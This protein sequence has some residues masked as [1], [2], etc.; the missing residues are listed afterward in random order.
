MGFRMTLNRSSVLSAAIV[1]GSFSLSACNV[2]DVV[3]GVD[4][5][6]NPADDAAVVATGEV[7]SLDSIVGFYEWHEDHGTDGRD[8][9]YIEID[10]YSNV[11]WY[12]FQGDS[13]DNNG[14]CYVIEEDYFTFDFVDGNTFDTD[15]GLATI[16]DSDGSG[17]VIDFDDA[18]EPDMILGKKR[19]MF[20]SDFTGLLCETSS[21]DMS[22]NDQ[23]KQ[24]KKDSHKKKKESNDNADDK[25]FQDKKE[26][27]KEKG[28]KGKK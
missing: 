20:A 9:G 13:Y 17:L 28:P 10:E 3:A 15:L 6:I 24:D 1:L 22:A 19:V 27:A 18:A 23:E 14:N 7:T 21:D 4:A 25:D 26:S 16:S 8:E 2:E 5:F 11:T 12:D